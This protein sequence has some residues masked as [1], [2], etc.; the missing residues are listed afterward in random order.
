[1]PVSGGRVT[2]VAYDVQVAADPKH[3]LIVDHQLTNAVSEKGLLS[4]IALRAKQAL[5]VGRLEVRVAKGY[6]HGRQ[7]KTCLEAGITPYLPKPNSSANTQLSLLGNEDFRYDPENDGAMCPGGEQLTFRF[8]S[9]EQGRERRTHATSACAHCAL[10][11]RCTRSSQGCR[12]TR[13]T[14]Q[15]PLGDM[16]RR[17]RASPEKMRLRKQ[18]AEHPFGTIKRAWNQGYLLTKGVQCV[19]AQMSLTALAYYI[20]R[21]IKILGVPRM[22]EA[23]A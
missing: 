5:G 11:L 6:C 17:V 23:L 9:T 1:M 15:D 21:A 12:L 4:M 8:Q 10:K 2:D 13:W 20:K 19:N 7:V 16:Q 3:K 18:L 22:M 14:Y